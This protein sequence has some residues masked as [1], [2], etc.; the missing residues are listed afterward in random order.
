M[1][2]QLWV[3]YF[4]NSWKKVR[5]NLKT[6]GKKV[7]NFSPLPV[8]HNCFLLCFVPTLVSIAQNGCSIW[9]TRLT[10]IVCPRAGD[11]LD[12][13]STQEHRGSLL[14]S[15]I[16]K[17][18]VIQKSSKLNSTDCSYNTQN[19]PTS[20][21]SESRWLNCWTVA[22]QRRCVFLSSAATSSIVP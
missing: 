10:C 16:R 9:I 19:Y 15:C 21:S 8:L 22:T 18:G 6:E 13:R 1:L 2:R 4:R 7:C 12:K 11:F 5:K 17:L 3:R 14:T 20:N